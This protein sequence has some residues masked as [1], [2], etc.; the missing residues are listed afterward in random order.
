MLHVVR[1][2]R[3]VAVLSAALLSAPWLAGCGPGRAPGALLDEA[4][5]ASH[6]ASAAEGAASAPDDEGQKASV[7]AAYTATVQ[8]EGKGDA[9]YHLARV[10]AAWVGHNFTQA[11]ETRID[12]RG[13]EVKHAQDGWRARFE[14]RAVRCGDAR[15]E[16]KASELR[17]ATD[18]PHRAAIA[19]VVAGAP[20]EEWAVNGPLGVEQG[21]TL[22]TDPCGGEA[23]EV[24]LEVGVEG[25]TPVA[26]GDAVILRDEA[27]VARARYGSV[28]AHD[29]SGAP[30]EASLAVNAG[31][32]DV[33]V[34]TEGARWPVTID[35][36][37][38]AQLA[39]VTQNMG[40]EGDRFGASV[41][42]S[43][44][45][46]LVGAPSSSVG[47][48]GAQG[49]AYVFALIGGGW[50]QQQKLT[51]GDGA[52]EDRFGTSVALSGTTA[53]VGAPKLA[54][55]GVASA[56][57]AY[58]FARTGGVWT[59]QSKLSS[60]DAAADDSFGESVALSGAS[61]LVGAPHHGQPGT[62]GVGALQGA[63]YLFAQ[64]GSGT[65]WTQQ[66]RLTA[67]DGER[68]DSF[69]S[70]VALEA[71][72][73]LVGASGKTLGAN[74]GQGAAY[75]FVQGV[76]G[77]WAQQ[78]ALSASDGAA[79]DGFGCSV[80]LSGAA[81]LVGANNKRVGAKDGQGAAYFFVLGGSGGWAQ[82]QALTASDGEALEHFG[83]SVALSGTTALVGAPDKNV[84]ANVWQ[85]TAYVFEQSGGV[86]IEQESLSATDGGDGDSLGRSVALSGT[87]ALLGAPNKADGVTMLREGAVSVYTV[88]N[89]GLN[90]LLQELTASDGSP[91][92]EFGVSVALSG[93]TAL[94]G[95]DAKRAGGN[96]SEGAAYLFERSGAD[97]ALQQKLMPDDGATLDCFGV[98]VALSDTTALVG[99]Y[100]ATVGENFQQ[101]AAYVFARSGTV[102]TQRKKLTASDGVPGDH[103]GISVALSGTTALVGAYGATVG[104][105]AAQGAAYV[106]VQRGSTWTEQYK[107][108]ASDGAAS[109]FFG[110]RVA[111]SGTTALV[112]ASYKTVGANAGQG[113]AYVF[114]QVGSAWAEQQRLVASD[115][116]ANDFFGAA[117]ALSGTTALVGAY[118]K[119]VGVNA[120]QGAA[121]LFQ[122]SGSAWTQWQRL[123]ASD[124]AGG[125]HF[126]WSVAL[127]G[128]TA[129][130]GASNKPIAS[131]EAQ[132][133]AY[134]YV[135]SGT[136]WTQE[137]ELTANDGAK[138]D[139]FAYAATLSGRSALLGAVAKT[140]RGHDGQGAAYVFELRGVAGSACLA[141][142]YCATTYA[143]AD[144]VCCTSD[145]SGA[146]DACAVARGATTDGTCT[147]LA[148]GAL[149]T[150]A[151]AGNLMC[152]GADGACPASC[153]AD[154]ECA[155]GAFCSVAGTCTPQ[156]LAGSA[157]NRIADC[158]VAQQGNCRECA[159]GN[160]VDGACCDTA[161]GGACD[162][163]NVP[164]HPGACTPVPAS[165]STACGAGFVCNG[166]VPVCP[167]ACT[168]DTGCQAGWFC[169][170]VV[171]P[172]V[173][174][175]QATNGATCSRASQCSSGYC[176]QGVCCGT[177][178]TGLCQACSAAAKSAGADGE[179]G[180]ARSGIDPGEHCALEGQSSCGQN[181]SCNGSGACDTWAS[182]A[183]S[184]GNPTCVGNESRPQRCTAART[185]GTVSGT[186]CGAYACSTTSGTCATACASDAACASGHYCDPSG[187]C[188]SR[189]S[190]GASCTRAA[191]CAL[192]NCVDGVC[193]ETA[194]GGRCQA[195]SNARKRQGA[196]GACG[197]IA[198]GEDPDDECTQD[199]KATC[200]QTGACNGAGACATWAAGTDCGNGGN[201]CTGNLVVGK[202]CSGVGA[203]TNATS[204]VD[205]GAQRC[206]GG[207]CAACATAADCSNPAASYCGAGGQCLAKKAQA[208]ACGADAE[209]TT[210]HCADGLCCD[211]ACAG[212]CEACSALKKGVAGDGVCGAVAANRDPDAECFAELQSTC[213]QNGSCDGNRACAVWPVGTSC[214]GAVCVGGESR[215]RTCAGSLSCAVS[216]SGAACG[217]YVCS[218][219]T[220]ACQT[221]C[222]SDVDCSA[223][224]FCSGSQCVARLAP[225][226]AC[227]GASACEGGHCVDGVCCD[228]ACA[229]LCEAC[230]AVKKGG[231]GLDGA[232]GAVAAS[233][234]PDA[235]CATQSQSTCGTNGQCDGARACAYWSGGTECG[236]PSCVGNE[237]RASVC[238]A[239]GTCGKSASGSACGNFVCSVATGLCA[240]SCSGDV[241]CAA[242]SYCNGASHACEPKQSAGAAC[243]GAAQCLSS[244]CV[245]GFCCD[246]A[247]GGTCV[248]CS[249]AKKGG[250]A[251]GACGAVGV[252]HDPDNE[253]AQ[254]A[255]ST[256]GTEGS[257]DG[258]GAC[259]FWAV[260]TLCGSASGSC[261]GNLLVGEVCQGPG[262][263]AVSAGGTPCAP[264]R[265]AG[266]RC[267]PCATADDCFAPASSYCAAGACLAKKGKG[268]ACGASLECEGSSCVDGYCCDTACAGLCEACS[269]VKKGQGADG[270]CGAVAAG[271]NPDGECVTTPAS[272]CGTS[273]TCDGARACAL[274][275][276]GQGCGADLCLGGAEVRQVC[277]GVGLCGVTQD[278]AVACAPYQCTGGHCLAGCAADADCVDGF[279][280]KAAACIAKLAQ[281]AVCAADRECG[282]G[283]CADGLCC[284]EACGGQCEACNL[285]G[286]EGACSVVT[287]SPVGSRKVCDGAGVCKGT[288]GGGDRT[289][290]AYPDRATE[291]ALASC[292]G[293]SLLNAAGCDG[294]GQCAPATH[295]PC[296]AYACGVGIDGGFACK[297]SCT[298]DTD[299]AG[300]LTCDPI[301]QTCSQGGKTCSVDGASEIAPD[302][303]E[304]RCGGYT[305][306]PVTGCAT[307]C[308]PQL[309][310]CAK[311]YLCAQ[312]K[313]V[314]ASDDGG[315]PESAT[316][317]GSDT[318]NVDQS[319]G[320][321]CRLVG[322]SREGSRPDG[323][324]WLAA[325]GLAATLVRRRRGVRAPTARAA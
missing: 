102:W 191:E 140:V 107:L 79:Q 325:L 136:A 294:A 238:T 155:A 74:G 211:T 18:A 128:T 226:A 131:K 205:C 201:V 42:V 121:Y 21:F 152:N 175:A 7:L 28:W 315:V 224:S 104:A 59:V 142:A 75:V 311:G 234:D 38:A 47:A 271:R 196:D 67:S 212:L 44:T 125:D 169:D 11:L 34:R 60:D 108:V 307:L 208:A 260:G 268:S 68:H 139:R 65:G 120:Q 286:S 298:N 153:G 215:P 277:D 50:S 113:G 15:G 27:G 180:N 101:G 185:C 51:A 97:W 129:L 13:F 256:C 8:A 247:C 221:A 281:G 71:T 2:G 163:C 266:G 284:N 323:V 318:L 70:S 290:C 35:P 118:D 159:S 258:N 141:D 225:G 154:V 310:P 188:V 182:T 197:P 37:V 36:L 114:A 299:C 282:L 115:G 124:G 314:V 199:A 26:K 122:Q 289:S 151:C 195:C 241:E 283:H 292:E 217:A 156:R 157:C 249:G 220:G 176:V 134:V 4:L 83:A 184:C 103:L 263:C 223:G 93:T 16:V 84:G 119:T 202:V 22:P 316:T 319:K 174:V 91:G 24:V 30:L 257:C 183:A 14:T 3:V 273:G 237:S 81:A 171:S 305:C 62:A 127:S 158:N 324:A 173:C 96:Y 92:D 243:S 87:T 40:A 322:A 178:C 106:F 296:G 272:T 32:I 248:A 39:E 89:P 61:A 244:F 54:V 280:C 269:A 43:S 304:K 186:A 170:L 82:K 145:C 179:C 235:E 177:A 198:A 301:K 63:A 161:C 255:P 31:A 206:V 116:A 300:N 297:S 303:S 192:G 164:G 293:E 46:A 309:Q 200:A 214:A 80:A 312:D 253:C 187:A 25:L 53:L 160:C 193:C 210:G 41:A 52:A 90:G 279:F 295:T 72:T 287:G 245:D 242:G 276:P 230:T 265:C 222:A 207:V 172:H 254:Q 233:S 78:Q 130:V 1:L 20:F 203:C 33:R 10:G 100:D 291:C 19:R 228:T 9:R 278:N 259:A 189:Q 64:V 288:C 147:P 285:R 165:S 317:A 58:V 48:N 251:D 308:D 236:A 73:A 85:G 239:P 5:A 181:G 57:A 49:A 227:S 95:A 86:W 204:G 12:V 98:S 264:L 261:N 56:G 45:I 148:Q 76:S 55:G 17:P 29:A 150:P 216:A 267:A 126:G 111:V 274:H 6:D 94:V 166:A 77:V 219:T 302:G 112:G 138:W 306:T 250:G 313:C 262:V 320:C 105:N 209:C 162:A 232:C 213:G 144:G 168:A 270:V 190:P 135:Q 99:A 167:A 132:G 69:G 321:G 88:G 229:G 252:Q 137:Q 143:C 117:V 66:Q 218:A 231:A 240:T 194:C 23:R 123:T 246:T 149:A 275:P 110:V 133:A 109:D 146:C